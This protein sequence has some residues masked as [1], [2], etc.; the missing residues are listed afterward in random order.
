MKAEKYLLKVRGQLT[1]SPGGPEGSGEVCVSQKVIRSQSM[2]HWFSRDPT[3][4]TFAHSFAQGAADSG[5]GSTAVSW[6]TAAPEC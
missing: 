2:L 5:A 3:T 4:A 6:A 1:E